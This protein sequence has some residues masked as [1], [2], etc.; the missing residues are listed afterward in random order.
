[1]T[2]PRHGPI[3]P[4]AAAHLTAADPVL[5][6]AISTLGEIEVQLEP[7]LWWSL[8]DAVVSQQLSVAAAATILRRV[9][10]L[11]PAGGRPSPQL[12]LD[13]PPDV[14]R[15]CG[16]SAA[17]TA[18]VKD[19]A[20]NFLSGEIRPDRLERLDDEEVIAQLTRVKGIGRWT[21]QMTLIFSLGRPDVL[22]VDDLGLRVAVER[23]YGLPSRP[24]ARQLERIATP[25]SPYRSAATIY[26]WRTRRSGG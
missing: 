9:E 2:A 18:Y 15:S 21:A 25:W 5:G 17:K 16:L 4:Q 19:L 6:G 11:V 13:T 3:P 24:A 14:L 20:A 7:D 26:L 8:V 10:A 22:P 12:L 1:M 23:L